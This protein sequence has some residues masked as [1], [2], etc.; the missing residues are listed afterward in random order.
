MSP[1]SDLTA[2]PRVA[3]GMI[4]PPP[5]A[6]LP[7]LS[8]SIGSMLVVW[9]ALAV[10]LAGLFGGAAVAFTRGRRTWRSFKGLGKT[11]GDRLDEITKAS[12]EIETHLSRA[13]E[14]S[15]HLSSS[16]ERLHRS[17]AR[18][19][20]QLAALREARTVLERAVPFLGGR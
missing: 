16:L 4:A 12:E 8:I 18:L 1:A 19:G 14:S 7:V 10:A 17:R 15:E 9:P 5:P 20:V 13:G 3:A 11:V 2:P 6:D